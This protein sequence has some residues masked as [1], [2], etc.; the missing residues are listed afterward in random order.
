MSL[1]PAVEAAM[2]ETLGH[3]NT[4]R[5]HENDIDRWTALFPAL[6]AADDNWDENDILDWLGQN[7]PP[8]KGNVRDDRNAMKVYAWAQMARHQH[9]EREWAERTVARPQASHNP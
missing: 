7:W 3:T 5:L 4:N 6:A 2:A 1:S 8:R 9:E